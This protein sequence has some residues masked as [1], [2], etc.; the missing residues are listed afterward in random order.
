[1]NND[2]KVM[3]VLDHSDIG[4]LGESETAVLE[5]TYLDL[6]ALRLFAKGHAAKSIKAKENADLAY[7]TG[8]SETAKQW[9]EIYR[10]ESGARTLLC[11][12]LKSLGVDVDSIPETYAQRKEV[13]IDEQE[14]Q[15][16][17]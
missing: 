17:Q 12:E 15:T 5:G 14:G 6:K 8:D 10:S 13:Q 9:M 1:M 4:C 2:E 16:L 11:N 3:Q 7:S